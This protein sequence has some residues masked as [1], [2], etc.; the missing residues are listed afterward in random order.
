MLRNDHNVTYKKYV[1]EQRDRAER[2]W[3][4]N[5][6]DE[7]RLF[8]TIEN[9]EKYLSGINNVLCAGI[10]KG[11]ELWAFKKVEM[12]NTATIFGID[13][14][15]KVKKVPINGNSVEIDKNCFCYDF[16]KMP[17]DWENKFDL[18]Y[19]NSIDHSYN[20]EKTLAE[21]HRVVRIGGFLLIV[22]SSRGYT[23]G[24]DLYD[25]EEKD[26]DFLIN[27]KMFDI[28]KIWRVNNQEN[29]FNVLLKN[30]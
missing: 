22:F 6:F 20:I 4:S 24:Y 1:S 16:N 19:S 13:I 7:K 18:L 25:F 23:S 26:M 15:E 21:W 11:R 27:K 8:E 14:H 12:F 17:K 28:L 2:K 10:R 5:T 29:T 30:K 3:G 9:I